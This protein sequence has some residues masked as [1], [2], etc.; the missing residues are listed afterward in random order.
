MKKF[1]DGN[2]RQVTFST[3]KALADA[4]EHDAEVKLA[5][6]VVNIRGTRMTKGQLLEG[7]I[8]L[9]VRSSEA[10]QIRM[11]REAI[12]AHAAWVKDHRP[13]EMGG[14]DGIGA[15]PA[16]KASGAHAKAATD[17]DP[18]NGSPKTKVRKKRA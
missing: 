3:F 13:E 15:P 17:R 7:Y 1:G 10:D 12:D 6:K 5:G 11:V 2:D 14:H 4:F 9:F 16:V 8:S 18:S